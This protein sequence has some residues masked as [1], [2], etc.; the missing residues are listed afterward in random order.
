MNDVKE[1]KKKLKRCPFCKNSSKWSLYVA[2]KFEEFD[3]VWS[4]SSFHTKY[5][6]KCSCG[7]RGPHSYISEEDAIDK[8]NKR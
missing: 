6:V 3:D 5:Y 2:D 7:A 8:W 1:N 4:S